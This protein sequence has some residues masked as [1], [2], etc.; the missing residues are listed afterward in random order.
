MRD[1]AWPANGTIWEVSDFAYSENAHGSRFRD[2]GN[3]GD[4]RFHL[5][6]KRSS[7]AASIS[8]IRET[9][10]M[11]DFANHGN[12]GRFAISIDRETVPL[13]WKD[14]AYLGN[15]AGARFR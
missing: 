9:R 3:P 13:G 4:A 6:G 11:R 15:D 5:A 7:L 14:F 12:L 8:L 2:F 1:F 10:P